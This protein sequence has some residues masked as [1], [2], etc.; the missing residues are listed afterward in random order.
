MI[1]D[2][3]LGYT[4]FYA[5]W[6]ASQTA[7]IWGFQFLN[8]LTLFFNLLFLL[9]F[10]N[11]KKEIGTSRF[12]LRIFLIQLKKL[13]PLFLFKK[14][15]AQNKLTSLSNILRQRKNI[16]IPLFFGIA[17]FLAL[18]LYGLYLKQ[19]WPEPDTK[20]TV[21]IIQPNIANDRQ[22]NE[23]WSEFI[24]SKILQ[25]TV[26]H[27]WIHSDEKSS[28]VQ[29]NKEREK[30]IVNQ[31]FEEKNSPSTE[32]IHSS[33]T[34]T[35]HKRSIPVDF[36]LWPEGAYPYPVDKVKVVKK[37]DHIQKWAS[38]FNTPLIASAKGKNK[39]EN[40]NS[41]FS[42]DQ[43]GYLIQPPYDKTMLMPFAE[44]IPLEKWF[45]SLGNLFFEEKTFTP[46]AGDNKIINLAGHQLGLQICYESLFDWFTRDLARKGADILLNV[47]NDSWFGK[48]QEPW[49]HL[50]MTA[51][52]TI[53]A[54]RPLI[55]GTNSGFS[56]VVSAK[57]DISSPWILNQTL[58]WIQ[59][60]PYLKGEKRQSFFTGWGYY[61]NQVFL[62][63]LLIFIY[64][65]FWMPLN[66]KNK[67]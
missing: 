46:G 17:L 28:A 3:H 53:E 1:F 24:L 59:E 45:P 11:L 66:L 10:Q 15:L 9:I 16:F 14:I 51:A 41:I 34:L 47:A 31:N 8:T 60:V 48:W 65:L 42:F 50:Y 20:I 19:R 33:K 30:L 61:L 18:N 40:T 35:E 12:S 23:E 52:R 43:Y 39:L 5:K 32:R 36:I 62:W 44:Y 21:L 57:G 64:C 29:K 13:E 67:F 55:R 6:P 58:S 27:L 22:D 38:V 25:E 56:A 4:W 2:W 37:G 7:E 54:R 63:V 49:Q 26:K